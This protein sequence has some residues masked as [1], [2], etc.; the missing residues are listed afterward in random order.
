VTG[1][2]FHVTMR[3]RD[4]TEKHRASSPLELLFDPTF[5]VAISSL[6]AQLAH[7]VSGGHAA[8]ALLPC[9]MATRA[10]TRATSP[11]GTGSSRRRSSRSHL[12]AAAAAQLAW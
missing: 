12:S 8:S 7:E 5:V 2:Q 11:S 1:P 4:R 10:G 3:A 9:L 6:A